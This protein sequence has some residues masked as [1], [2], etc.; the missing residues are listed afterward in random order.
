MGRFGAD[1]EDESIIEAR[2][3]A[4]NCFCAASSPSEA[5]VELGLTG[6]KEP[7]RNL[8]WI[9][10]C[11]LFIQLVNRKTNQAHA[12]HVDFELNKN[13][14]HRDQIIF[15]KPKLHNKSQVF[16]KGRE[17]KDLARHNER[18]KAQKWENEQ[19]QKE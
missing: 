18:A 1:A 15:C 14:H 9:V 2:R 19:Q 12:K 4:G 13:F 3:G 17:A 10:P 7:G 5:A 11:S 16:L 6:S 8:P